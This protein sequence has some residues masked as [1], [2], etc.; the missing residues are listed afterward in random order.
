MIFDEPIENN[1]Y[2]QYHCFVVGE[3]GGSY[4]D[5]LAVREITLKNATERV[6]V[7]ADSSDYDVIV[8]GTHYYT[9]DQVTD[10]SH[11]RFI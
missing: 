8:T 6:L 5:G 7:K 10:S 1:Q 4:H 2:Y 3:S 9:N 11:R